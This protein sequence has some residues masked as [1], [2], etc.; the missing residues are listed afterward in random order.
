[1]L[2]GVTVDISQLLRFHFI[3]KVYYKKVDCHFPSDSLEQ[4]G[5]IVGILE[6]CSHALSCKVLN[7]DTLK[8]VHSFLIC[9]A[10]STNNNVPDGGR[11]DV[12]HSRHNDNSKHL[13][14][15]TPSPIVNTEDLIRHTFLMDEQTDGQKIRACIV[16]MIDDHDF[17]RPAIQKWLAN[18]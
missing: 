7:P 14:T 3:Q 4:V 18:P 6:H 5:H 15:S 1:M 17:N 9:P 10:T 11:P 2:T 8:I 12:I 16:K 13:T